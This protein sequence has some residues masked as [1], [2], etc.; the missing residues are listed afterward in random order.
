MQSVWYLVKSPYFSTTFCS[1]M[2]TF[3]SWSFSDPQ[4]KI[5]LM[6]NVSNLYL[7]FTMDS[8][9]VIA[10]KHSFVHLIQMLLPLTISTPWGKAVPSQSFLGN[11]WMIFPH[12]SPEPADER[13]WKSVS[14]CAGY[15]GVFYIKFQWS[16]T[17]AHILVFTIQVYTHTLLY[18]VYVLNV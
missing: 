4:G 11:R 2:F 10:G 8:G 1:H 7:C 12:P 15:H 18:Y 6:F 9:V 3:K 17:G 13:T 16:N 5:R 14:Q